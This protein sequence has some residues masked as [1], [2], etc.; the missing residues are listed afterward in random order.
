MSKIM[1]EILLNIL[2]RAWKLEVSLKELN[3]IA[4]KRYD[5]YEYVLI[6]SILLF[7]KMP[8]TML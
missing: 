1:F 6:S 8:S 7:P 4:K 3:I 2:N 5:N